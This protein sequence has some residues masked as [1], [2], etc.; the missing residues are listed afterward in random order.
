MNR[1]AVSEPDHPFL[2][3]CPCQNL[4]NHQNCP[5]FKKKCLKSCASSSS[6]SIAPHRTHRVKP[7]FSIF[8][9]NIF[10]TP[11]GSP[12]ALVL[13]LVRMPLPCTECSFLCL[14]APAISTH[15]TMKKILFFIAFFLP[16]VFAFSPAASV[17]ASC[18]T[19]GNV[20]KT[21]ST[22]A[23]MTFAWDASGGTGYKVY[24][25]RR[26]DGYTSQQ[27]TTTNTSFTFP[28]LSAGAYS[29]YFASVC[30]GEV[31]GYIVVDDLNGV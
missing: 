20:H 23:S 4:P 2:T 30:G 3:K 13:P 11:V 21:G 28:G 17:D 9:G 8:I 1:I 10:F 7:F 29:F 16:V 19:P 5:F 25:V 27:W 31:S 12:K 14:P 26:S 22:D 24:Y 18:D 6:S 15:C